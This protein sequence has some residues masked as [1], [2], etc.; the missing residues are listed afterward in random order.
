[1]PLAAFRELGW[2]LRFPFRDGPT[3]CGLA[4]S[5]VNLTTA[6]PQK[7]GR[8]LLQRLTLVPHRFCA[9]WWQ[10]FPVQQLL[11]KL[12]IEMRTYQIFEGK[13]DLV[14]LPLAVARARLG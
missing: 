6:Q 3:F 10:P 7:M 14:V 13:R 1:V 8:W 4:V 5:G 12:R 11:H 2:L 9:F